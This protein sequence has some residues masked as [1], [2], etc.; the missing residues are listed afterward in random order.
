MTK[1]SIVIPVYNEEATLAT[2][3]NMVETTPLPHGIIREIVIIDDCSKD[4]TRDVLKAYESN[5]TYKISYHSINQGKGAALRT[6]FKEATGDIILVQD[7]DL[8]YAPSEYPQLLM[9]ILENKADVV[10]GSR[11]LG[12]APHRVLYF[13][14]R[15][16]N[17]MITL[18]SNMFSDLNFTDVETCYKVFRKSV[19]DQFSIEE[20]RFGFDPEITAKIGHLS[21]TQG[22]R[23][24]EI[25]ISY[26]GRTYEE[27]KKIGLKDAFRAFWCILLYNTTTFAILKKYTLSSLFILSLIGISLLTTTLPTALTYASSTLLSLVLGYIIHPYFTFRSIL[28][29]TRNLRNFIQKSLPGLLIGSGIFWGLSLLGISLWTGFWI[30][31]TVDMF[32]DYFC[33]QS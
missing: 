28:K 9:P 13:W 19:I 12:G 21:R 14:H 15:L 22:L 33:Y 30:A 4:K 32:I 6:G 10:Y 17:G 27:G 20:N 2:L 1:L 31:L 7:A 24:Y 26:F 18:M 5:P 3:L 11:F 16:A 8:E 29:P 23:I 25:G